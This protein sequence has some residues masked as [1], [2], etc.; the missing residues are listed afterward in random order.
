MTRC[1]PKLGVKPLTG[2]TGLTGESELPGL[3]ARPQKSDRSAAFAPVCRETMILIYQP[4]VH[5]VFP[6][7]RFGAVHFRSSSGPTE[8]SLLLLLLVTTFFHLTLAG[9]QVTRQNRVALV[10]LQ[11]ASNAP[12]QEPS[13]RGVRPA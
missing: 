10:R 7:C 12:C 9:V 5:L 4:D 11:V 13:Q 2:G 1:P 8:S 3:S 6:G